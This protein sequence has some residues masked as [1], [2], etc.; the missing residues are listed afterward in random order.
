M[1]PLFILFVNE[2]RR[3]LAL[4]KRKEALVSMKNALST[5]DVNPAAFIDVI[6]IIHDLE[7]K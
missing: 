6:G 2:A 5:R 1:N 4:G 7:R 3:L